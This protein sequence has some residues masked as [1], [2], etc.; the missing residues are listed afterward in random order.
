MTPWLRIGALACALTLTQSPVVAM[1]DTQAKIQ[2]IGIG[3]LAGGAAGT[4]TYGIMDN[5]A[6][7]MLSKQLTSI[8]AGLSV[9]LGAGF[10]A[11]TV[12]ATHTIQG[13]LAVARTLV[14]SIETKVISSQVYTATTLEALDKAL[15][16]EIGTPWPLIIA[17]Q[18][19]ENYL[20]SLRNVGNYL[21]T[22]NLALGPDK[23]NPAEQPLREQ[24]LTTYNRTIRCKQQL[25]GILTL[26]RSHPAYAQQ[27]QFFEQVQE[28]VAL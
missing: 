4:L 24:Y 12:L 23:K 17:T 21:V 6:A 28:Q 10:L 18:R 27:R 7:T 11:C 13:Q 3:I 19:T 26:L 8:S 1:T 25:L 20:V 15:L 2:G 5:S 14:D 16:S 22:I 9:A